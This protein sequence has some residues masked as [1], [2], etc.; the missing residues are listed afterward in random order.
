M[1]VVAVT[2]GIASGKSAVCRRLAEH[3]AVVV[4][5]DQVARDVVAPGEPA[6]TRIVEEF[7]SGVLAADGSLDRS[8][9]GA[10]VF[11]DDDKR[12]LLNAI[13]HPAIVQRSQELFR[14]AGEA[15]PE[16]IVVYDLPLLVEGTGRRGEFDLVVVVVADEEARVQRMIE[17]RGMTRNE[18]ERRIAAQATDAER[19]AVADIVIDANGS[20]EE[21]LAQ[22]DALWDKL[23][24]QVRR[25]A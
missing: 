12:M 15:D 10:I 7:G 1:L 24:E 3:G 13:T 25:P 22:A 20:L 2:G 18:A 16:A 23:Q 21:T 19:L 8:A 11:A 4:D 14:A 9:L 5:A 17:F 6:L